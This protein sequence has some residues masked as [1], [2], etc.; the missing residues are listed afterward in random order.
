MKRLNMSLRFFVLASMVAMFAAGGAAFGGDDAL[1]GKDIQLDGG[2]FDYVKEKNSVVLSKYAVVVIG[3]TRISARNMVYNYDTKE[4]YAEGDVVF[5]EAGGS[6]FFCD[7]LFFNTIEWHGIA[8][9]MRAKAEDPNAKVEKIAFVS[10]AASGP[11]DHSKSTANVSGGIKRMV[12]AADQIRAIDQKTY[13]A[14]NASI[15]PSLFA[16]PHWSL[17]SKSMIVR[18]DEKVES[19]HNFVRIGR[20]PIFYFP[21]IIKD[22]KYDWPWMRVAVANTSDHGFSVYTKTGMDLDQDNSKYF[23]FDNVFYD[24]D[25]RE[26]RGW[27]FGLETKYLVGK[28]GYGNID[29][30]YTNEAGI[31]NKDDKERADDKN[32]NTVW[33][34]ESNWERDLYKDSDR[35]MIDWEH[36]QPINDIWDIRGELH[37]YHDRDFK[38]EYFEDDFKTDKEPETSLDLRRWDPHWQF[39]LVSSVRANQWQSQTEY[40]P[41]AR[42]NVPGF[43]I[44]QLPLYLKYN[45]RFGHLRRSFDEDLDRYGQLETADNKVKHGDSYETERLH[46]RLDL[47]MP[48]NAGPVVFRPFVAGFATYYN[49]IYGENR[50]NNELN[51][52]ELSKRANN[53]FVPGLVKYGEE[54][55]WNT[56][57]EYGMD[58]STRLYGLYKD[59]KWRHVFEPKL[60]FFGRENPQVDPDSLYYFDEV[61]TFD[62]QHYFEFSLNNKLQER[63]GT[64]F[65]EVVDFDV[66]FRY[67]PQDEE[68][69]QYVFDPKDAA[70]Y[71]RRNAT[72]IEFDLIVRPTDRLT[73]TAAGLVDPEDMELNRFYGSADWQWQDRLRLYVYHQYYRGNYWRYPTMDEINRTTFAVRLPLWDDNSKYAAEVAM[74]YDW[75]S[76]DKSVNSFNGPVEYRFSL[77][78]D[79]DT[80]ELGVSLIEDKKDDDR[81]IFIELRPKGWM[82]MD[83]PSS[84]S[85]GAS[86]L[87]PS[88]Y[89]DEVAY[90][91][92]NPDA[93]TSSATLETEIGST[94]QAAAEE[95]AANP[96]P[97]EEIAPEEEDV[98]KSDPSMKPGQDDVEF[99]GDLPKLQ[100]A[101]EDPDAGVN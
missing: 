76:S 15:T 26:L 66:K 11:D 47:S 55:R 3:E 83:R 8:E 35:Y 1:F 73:L 6:A 34:S 14:I 54:S 89:G 57:I 18:K 60:T 48:I 97:G 91:D 58:I 17:T 23:R 52:Y 65:R 40:L 63:V 84:V 86:R 37:Y 90:N 36:F 45:A 42:I 4:V 87:M 21:Y 30:Y 67:Y 81:G 13:E 71:D 94:I 78:R 93:G 59:N 28:T 16:R 74:S 5:E 7:K 88:R 32:D 38:E 85:D 56:G 53:E 27:S 51:A 39:E 64:G 22:L 44:G 98:L 2:V 101:G 41:E 96:A 9:H 99:E 92:I 33:R 31:S 19:W 82:G 46:Q 50:G 70:G 29:V 68:A 69:E 75:P 20:V 100:G 80:F 77:Y 25:W 10:E 43:Q 12:I 62:E 61:D 79:I 49:E 95:D 72:E 24:I